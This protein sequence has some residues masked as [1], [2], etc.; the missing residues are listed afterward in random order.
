MSHANDIVM[1]FP[2]RRDACWNM[3]Y[4]PLFGLANDVDYLKKD[5]AQNKAIMKMIQRLTE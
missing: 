1:L 4:D 3:E 5:G 2:N